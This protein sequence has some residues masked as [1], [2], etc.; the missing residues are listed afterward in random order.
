MLG[1]LALQKVNDFIL[2]FTTQN[3]IPAG[4]AIQ[5]VMATGFQILYQ[6]GYD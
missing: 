1:K 5:V 6:S 4:G 3:P 2:S